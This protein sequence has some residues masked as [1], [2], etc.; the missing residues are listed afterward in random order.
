MRLA[1]SSPAEAEE[2]R[3]KV[4]KLKELIAFGEQALGSQ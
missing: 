4:D 1:L 3:K 2:R